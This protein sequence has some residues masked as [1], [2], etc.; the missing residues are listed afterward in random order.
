MLENKMIMTLQNMLL[1]P[2]T[3][4]KPKK[5]NFKI[6]DIR[7]FSTTVGSVSKPETSNR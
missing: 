2:M 1:N 3:V 5:H 6:P 4:S 7:R